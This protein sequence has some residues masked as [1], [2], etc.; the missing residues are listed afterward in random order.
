MK[1]TLQAELSASDLIRI[2]KSRAFEIALI[3]ASPDPVGIFL[4]KMH[5]PKHDA[6]VAAILIW[7]EAQKSR[8]KSIIPGV[9]LTLCILCFGVTLV[10]IGFISN[11]LLFGVGVGT[12]AIC[13]AVLLGVY[14]DSK[15][16]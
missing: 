8:I 1:K 3:S 14:V 2:W 16:R 13:A 5:I 9:A 7:N 11:F 15:Q 6:S 12:V 4:E 10:V